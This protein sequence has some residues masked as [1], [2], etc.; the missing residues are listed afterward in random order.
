MISGSH[1]GS[2]FVAV[3]VDETIAWLI[4]HWQG[5]RQEHDSYQKLFMRADLPAACEQRL[6]DAMASINAEWEDRQRAGG[7][8]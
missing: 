7:A 1:V 6:R 3:V 5:A 4:G 2:I 8:R